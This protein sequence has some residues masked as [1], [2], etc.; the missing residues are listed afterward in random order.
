[1][2]DEVVIF[3]KPG[4]PYCAAAKKDLAE[5]GISFTEQDVTSNP[6]LKEEAIRLAGQAAVP[7][8]VTN[9]EVAVGFGGS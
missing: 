2:P 1:M 3:T 9:G 7:V 5:K 6:V 8:I 4:C